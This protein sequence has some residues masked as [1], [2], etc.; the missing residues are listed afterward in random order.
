[1]AAE[2]LSITQAAGAVTLTTLARWLVSTM[3]LA[4]PPQG[5][6]PPIPTPCL[7][8]DR[9]HSTFTNISPETR[10]CSWHSHAI[11]GNKNGIE[12]TSCSC[13]FL[14]DCVQYRFEVESTSRKS[15]LPDQ[16]TRF[17]VTEMII[18]TKEC[19][20]GKLWR[21]HHRLPASNERY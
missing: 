11:Q 3:Q 1:M 5:P 20:A 4:R 6:A 14:N 7:V 10:I 15:V 21:S 8:A 16:Q 19:G 18:A 2:P 9:N 17:Q 12:I 13:K